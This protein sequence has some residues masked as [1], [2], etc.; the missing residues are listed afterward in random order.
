MQQLVFESTGTCTAEVL[1]SRGQLA[2]RYENWS[3]AT[4]SFRRELELAPDNEDINVNDA[5]ALRHAGQVEEAAKYE[6]RAWQLRQLV[7][8]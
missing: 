2:L 7:E 8:L 1:L 5:L 4:N 6:A 3:L